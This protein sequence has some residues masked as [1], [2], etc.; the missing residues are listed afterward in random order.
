LMSDPT[1]V[2][3]TDQYFIDA[4]NKRWV[5]CWEIAEPS[6]PTFFLQWATT[7]FEESQ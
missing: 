3:V 5:N 2:D 6:R 1:I 7:G 4:L